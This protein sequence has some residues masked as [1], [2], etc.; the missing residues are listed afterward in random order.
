MAACWSKPPVL[1][2]KG[3]LCTA[4]WS[5]LALRGD[6]LHV[7]TLPAVAAVRALVRGRVEPGARIAADALSLADIEAET[8]PHAISTRCEMRNFANTVFETTLGKETVARLPLAVR[9]FHGLSGAP[10]WR[11][12]AD[13][14]TGGGWPGRLLRRMLGM[15]EAAG[16]IP[17]T[18]DRL[19]GSQQGCGGTEIWTRNFAGQRFSWR[20]QAQQSGCVIETFGPL[21]FTLDLAADTSGLEMPVAGWRFCGIPMPRFLRPLSQAREFEDDHG[22]FRFD[23]RLSLPVLGLLIHYLGWLSPADQSERGNETRP[24]VAGETNG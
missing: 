5:L 9:T 22:R 20:L 23:V 8:V 3:R 4:R 16:D 17:V 1:D 10:V 6:G 24:V 19:S 7:S 21:S 15:P 2:A 11:G 12:A 18:V 13:I 14:E